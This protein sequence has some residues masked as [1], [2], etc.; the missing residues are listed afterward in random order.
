M[1]DETDEPQL[2]ELYLRY[3]RRAHEERFRTMYDIISELLRAAW[4]RETASPGCQKDWSSGNPAFGQCA[5][6][7]LVVQDL[8]GGTLVRGEVP[9]F[10]SHYWN[11][12]PNGEGVHTYDPTRIQFPYGTT[13][14]RGEIVPRSRLLEGGRAVAAKTSE[15]YE[16]LKDRLRMLMRS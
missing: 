6:S 15:R 4:C 10:G 3:A 14:P 11:E 8:L 2:H 1:H 5:V 16:L 9:G 12:I 7:A 13:F